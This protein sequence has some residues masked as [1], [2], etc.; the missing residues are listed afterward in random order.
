MVPLLKQPAFGLLI[1]LLAWQTASADVFRKKFTIPSVYLIVEVLD[2]DL[3][4]FE[5]S[6]V[7]AGP[8]A[9]QPLYTSP[10][11]LKTDYTGPSSLTET[12]NRIETRDIRLDIDPNNLCIVLHDKTRRGAYLTTVCP[13]DIH[14]PFKGLNID[15][16]AMQSV[17]GL[18]QEFKNLGSANGDWT[19]LGVRQGVGDLGNGFQGFQNAAVGNVQIP[20]MYLTVRSN[21]NEFQRLR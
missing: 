5:V 7:G 11:V 19:S 14:M 20:V 2:D 8:T 6:A 12:G 21:L 17:Y 16:G 3:V 9:A 4:H 18:G 13:A 1:V 10:M 15:P